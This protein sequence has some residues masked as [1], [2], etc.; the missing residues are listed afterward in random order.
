MTDL[1]FELALGDLPD[2]YNADLSIATTLSGR[3]IPLWLGDVQREILIT[4]VTNDHVSV[5]DIRRLVVDAYCSQDL[6]ELPKDA[7][8]TFLGWRVESL[9]ER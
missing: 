6:G 8:S 4:R 7:K 3:R 2:T 5:D 1:R 9:T